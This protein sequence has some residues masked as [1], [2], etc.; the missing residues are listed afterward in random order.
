M[1]VL[2][3]NFYKITKLSGTDK[4]FCEGPIGK[5]EC[6]ISIKSMENSKSPGSDGLPAEFY[7]KFFKYLKIHLLQ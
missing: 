7:K 1:K 5:K 2:Q 6:R 4:Q 3:M